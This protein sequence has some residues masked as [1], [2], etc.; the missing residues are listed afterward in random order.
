MREITRAQKARLGIFLIVSGGLLI[1]LL[2][3]VTGAKILEQRDLYYIRYQDTSVSGLEIGAQVKYHGVRIGRVEDIS[4]DP[5]EIETVIITLALRKGTPVTKDMKAVVSALSL[6]GLKQIELEGGSSASELLPPG[7]TITPGASSLQMLSGRAEIVAEKLELV[8]TNLITLTGSENQQKLFEMVD[9][10]AL[11]LMDVH[12][13][14]AENR[15]TIAGTI[16]NLHAASEGLRELSESDALRRA[17]ANLDTTT[18]TIRRAQIDLAVNDL[19][20]AL[21]QARTT[22][23]HIDLTLLKGRHDLL[24]S[25]EVLRESLDSFNEFARAISEDPSL[26]LRGSKEQEISPS[27]LR[28]R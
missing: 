9:N 23:T 3:I 25:L 5:K 27:K 14:L 17:F 10:T 12:E 4:I 2:L 11:V 24:T 8:L 20:K 13:M 26:L 18:A 22:F 16:D 21:E 28:L 15:E 7:S 1:V 19:R 6:T